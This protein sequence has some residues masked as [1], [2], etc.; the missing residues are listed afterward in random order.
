MRVPF[1]FLVLLSGIYCLHT[2]VQLKIYLFQKT[3]K[4]AFLRSG[5]SALAPLRPGSLMTTML[6]SLDYFL[7]FAK[8]GLRLWARPSEEL[9]AIEVFISFIVQMFCVY[10]VERSPANTRRWAS[11]GLMKGQRRRWWTI[12]GPLLGQRRVCWECWW[13]FHTKTGLNPA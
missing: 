5:F 4:N 11:A 10:W 8:D 1:L 6:I 3:V 2:F 12:I 13:V 9:G 7:E